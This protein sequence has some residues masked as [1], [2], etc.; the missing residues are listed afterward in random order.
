MNLFIT[1]PSPVLSAQYL[2]DKRVVNQIRETGQMLCTSLRTRGCSDPRLMASTHHNHPVT[3]WV[4]RTKANWSWTFRHFEALAAEK[5]RRWPDNPPHKNWV[6][7]SPILPGLADLTFLDHPGCLIGFQN[8]ARNESLGLDFSDVSSVP[9][10]Y[11][12]YLAARWETDA[13]PP[14]WTNL[15][16]PPWCHL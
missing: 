5:L 9:T 16:P 6:E 2:D 8:S 14:R 3:L 13:R 4:G 15:Q 1:H 12:R 11:R 10:A 7:L